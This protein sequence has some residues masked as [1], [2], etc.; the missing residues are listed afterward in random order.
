MDGIKKE[1]EA[2]TEEQVSC[3]PLEISSYFVFIWCL[4]CNIINRLLNY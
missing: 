1:K 3:G 4:F 2:T